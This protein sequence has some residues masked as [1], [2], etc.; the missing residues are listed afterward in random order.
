M[1]DIDRFIE[2]I[3]VLTEDQ[4]Q[5]IINDTMPKGHCVK[6]HKNGSATIFDMNNIPIIRITPRNAIDND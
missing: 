5:D 3:M 6:K 2:Q 4:A 1:L